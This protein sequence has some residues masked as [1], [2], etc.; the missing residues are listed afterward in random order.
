MAQER[1]FPKEKLEANNHNNDTVIKSW[2]KTK[3]NGGRGR[4]YAGAD[5]RGGGQ[6]GTRRR[7]D[8]DGCGGKGLHRW[9]VRRR[10]FGGDLYVEQS[11]YW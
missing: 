6:V 3:E 9:Q 10:R 4:N 2:K 7:Q 11:C 5:R 8:L 1:R